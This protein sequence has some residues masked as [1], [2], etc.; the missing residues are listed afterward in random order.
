MLS[1]LL[2][3]V[4]QHG[5]RAPNAIDGVEEFCCLG[6]LLKDSHFLMEET[7]LRKLVKLPI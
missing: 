7:T 1:L 5:L 2:R 4:E 6:E 3:G